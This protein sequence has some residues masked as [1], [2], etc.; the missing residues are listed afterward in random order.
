MSLSSVR[1]SRARR[2]RQPKGGGANSS[3]RLEP[4]CL[5]PSEAS[6]VQALMDLALPRF[7]G[8]GNGPRQV[9]LPWS[10]SS[11]P[12]ESPA[13]CRQ[14]SSEQEDFHFPGTRC[15]VVGVSQS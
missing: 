8:L 5:L 14:D 12:P 11:D 6:T 7:A 13:A 10:V 4:G 1:D 2:P 15:R 9:H 3:M